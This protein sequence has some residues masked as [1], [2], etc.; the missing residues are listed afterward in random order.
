MTARSLP[1]WSGGVTST[2]QTVIPCREK[3]AVHNILIGL[4]SHQS[5]HKRNTE[6]AVGLRAIRRPVRKRGGVD[7]GLALQ[8]SKTSA[9]VI[10]GP[11]AELHIGVI[12]SLLTGG[13]PDVW[14]ARRENEH[15]LRDQDRD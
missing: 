12:E 7:D 11:T 6:P 2:A 5:E 13:H 10:A 1:G 9:K 15:G 8:Y 3:K 4:H 14:L